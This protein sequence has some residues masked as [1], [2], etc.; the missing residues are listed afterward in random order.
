MTSNNL[1][2]PEVMQARQTAWL[3]G[4]RVGHKPKLSAVAGVALLLASCLVTFA[5]WGQVA[6]K[7]RIPGV[8]MPVQ[9]TVQLSANAPGVLTDQLVQE[10]EQVTAGQALFVL[11]TDRPTAEGS[12]AVLLAAHLAQR[13][14]TL[15]A[16]RTAR[17]QQTRQ[18]D[19]ALQDR[20][21]ALD[22]EITQAQQ[23]AVLAS[24]RVALA[25]KTLSRYQQMAQEGFVSDIQAQNK[26]EELID[27]QARVENT[28]R[29][30]ATLQ[31]EQQSLQAERQAN[32]RQLNID[33]SQ[34]DRALAGLAQEH[35]EN[36]SRQTIVIT[37]PQSGVVSSIHLPK[38]ASVQAGQS[39]ATLLPADANAP[40]KTELQATLYAPSRTAGFIQPGQTVW[41]RYG[42]YPYQKFGLAQGR[43]HHISTTPTA[44][45]DLPNGQG[46]ALQTAAQTQEPLYRIQV[47]LQEQSI[48]AYGESLPLKPG[49]TLEADVVQ[50]KRAVWEWVF[51][52]V[53][54]ARQKVK[55]L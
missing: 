24:S 31:R 10:G 20:I 55:V 14:S 7:S 44:P 15:E 54:A 18:R 26:Q 47:Q 30:A 11:G 49:M 8:L 41:M 21:R 3:G 23:E 32:Q 25:K 51:E 50:E 22:H 53:L 39:V 48:T 42:A 33:L 5:V 43:V 13:R 19:S 34:L 52:P 17:V 9:G 4:I 46:A 38:G 28:Q 27:L 37:A 6:R 36:Q 29:N 40:V 12:A 35:T 2:R 45:Q 1:F 16:E